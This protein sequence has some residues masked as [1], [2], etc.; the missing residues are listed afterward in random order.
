[1][2]VVVFSHS[3]FF[4]SHRL[5]CRYINRQATTAPDFDKLATSKNRRFWPGFIG[6]RRWSASD[7][8]VFQLCARTW[9]L[10]PCEALEVIGK[11]RH[12]DFDSGTGDADGA[13]KRPRPVLL[14]GEDVLNSRTHC[15][16]PG[17]GSGDALGHTG[18]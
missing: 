3:P 9:P 16:A 13:D 8:P 10:E 2:Q 17:I 4:R 15:G 6:F 7:R 18:A 14:Y 11:V 1:M 12:A 5:R